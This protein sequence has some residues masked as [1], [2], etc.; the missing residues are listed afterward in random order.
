MSDVAD[1]TLQ[2]PPDEMRRFGY[3]VIDS[4]VDHLA[5]L[6]SQPTVRWADRATMDSRLQEPPPREASDPMDVLHRT[7][8]DVL[9]YGHRNSHPRYFGYVPNPSN[10]VGAMA[11]ALAAG[12]NVF[13]G[14]WVG[15]PGAAQ[16]ELVVIDWLRRWCGMPDGAGGL[17]LSG[18]SMANL[19]G[20]A[21]ARH[22]CFGNDADA[23]RRGTIYYSDQ[24]HSSVAKGARL[25]GIGEDRLRKLPSDAEYRQSADTL[26]EA[27]RADQAA[28]LV[29]YCVIA[30]AGTTNT[31]AVDP[32]DD[33]ADV[34][35][36]EGLWLHADGAFAAAAILT[37]GGREKLA[38]IGRVDSLALDAHKWLFQPIECGCLLVRNVG[39]LRAAFRDRPEYLLDVDTPEEEVNFCDLGPQLTREFRALKLWMS[40]QVFGEDAF[41]TAVARG[42]ELAELAERYLRAAG[43]WEIVT[44]AQLGVLTFRRAPTGYSEDERDRL[45]LRILQEVL[46]DGYA[47]L[48]STIL[49]GRSVLRV[50]VIN[51]RASDEEIAETV[52]RVT[53]IAVRLAPTR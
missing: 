28:G 38:G 17:L 53:A 34:C 37:R 12:F 30:A 2:L 44:P 41:R 20:I 29:P 39:H 13:S 47:A 23:A 18:S 31:G 1:H 4:I 25:I 35:H 40:I 50:C 49:G 15:S 14:M 5:S 45:N 8:R 26:S 10:Y 48:S 22:A 21:T 24:A 46:E 52:R 32:L 42:M 6:P 11:D 19:V 16:V 7:L 9:S 3:A 43:G 51:P 36:A 33:L 27:I